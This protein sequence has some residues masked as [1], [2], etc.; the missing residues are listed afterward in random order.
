MQETRETGLTLIA[1]LLDR[2]A[3]F[4]QQIPPT[5]TYPTPDRA[6]TNYAGS[7]PPTTT[8][9]PACPIRAVNRR[10]RACAN[11]GRLRVRKEGPVRLSLL[12]RRLARAGRDGSVLAEA[13]GK[14]F[15]RGEGDVLDIAAAVEDRDRGLD[16]DVK[17]SREQDEQANVS[18]V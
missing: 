18:G 17:L 12:G 9:T 14:D 5:P 11:D 16:D 4:F 7:S 10:A 13:G 15:V 8:R 6:P 1:P 3:L 2:L